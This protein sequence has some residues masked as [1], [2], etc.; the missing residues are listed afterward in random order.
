MFKFFKIQRAPFLG[1][2]VFYLLISILPAHSR[3][4]TFKRI[5][6][7]KEWKALLYFENGSFLIKDPNFYVS[8]IRAP[9]SELKSFVEEIEN[10]KNV[11]C[12]FPARYTYLATV[13]DYSINEL[14]KCDDLDEFKK[15]APLQ[16]AS[17][18]FASENISIP[19]SM[20]GHIYLKLE[21]GNHLGEEVEHAISFFTDVDDY[22]IPKLIFDTLIVGKK[23]F[24]ALTPNSPLMSKYL[25]DEGR[26]VWEYEL[27]LSSYQKE[28]LHNH[29]FELK[30]I[31]LTYY[32]HTF[33]CA[34]LMDKLINVISPRAYSSDHVWVTP[35]DVVRDIKNKKIIDKTSVYLASKWKVKALQ[36]NYTIDKKTLHLIKQKNIDGLLNKAKE[37]NSES[38]F[39]SAELMRA[40]LHFEGE[41]I[42]LKRMDDL[43]KESY[44]SLSLDLSSYKN[45]N[46]TKSTSQVLAQYERFNE[47][48]IFKATWLPAS[49]FIED[50]SS[51]YIYESELQI[52]RLTLAYN[53]ERK[54]FFL[55]E[56]NIY[57][58]T[59]LQATDS[60]TGGL[61]GK[62]R[63]G[64]YN[65]FN[66]DLTQ[67]QSAIAQGSIGKTI[68]V[69]HDI[70]T[71]GLIGLSYTEANRAMLAPDIEA[72]LIV[73]EIFKMKTVMSM[74]YQVEDVNKGES[75]LI[76]N[77]KH[78]IDF[79]Q[80]GLLLDYNN[81][82]NQNNNHV[83]KFSLGLKFYF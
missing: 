32:F 20:M 8:N 67:N 80:Y 62:I 64:Y 78:F 30:N 12:K 70:D 15:R 65:Y 17:V 10:N 83:Q 46:Q 57:S 23:G 82:K 76:F 53:Q 48:N 47:E 42:S 21:G 50:D 22:N 68:R 7:S 79:N 16:K 35:L 36:E 37:D 31:N 71:F 18:V 58:S 5:S 56:F 75:I 28:L 51:N 39:L 19:S 41:D 72:G 26:N 1:L 9:D 54:N 34:T 69:H 81:F 43:I 38:S 44:S 2:V 40:Y 25:T 52:S 14:K 61:S 45:P 63:I 4:E 3:E 49:H 27:N 24:Y 60:L 59:S 6:T 77:L 13:L 29:L 33:N 73:R 74:K 11:I 66:S 55:D